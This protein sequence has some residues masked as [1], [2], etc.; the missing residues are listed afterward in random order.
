MG[1]VAMLESD[2]EKRMAENYEIIQ[3]VRIGGKEVVFGIDENALS[4]IF[5][6]FIPPRILLPIR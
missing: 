3:A 5:A 2:Q 6:P 1:G 4:H